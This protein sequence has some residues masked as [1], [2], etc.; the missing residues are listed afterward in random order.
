M[1]FDS[2]SGP[3]EQLD[4][5]A[6]AVAVF[7]DEKPSDGFL[8]KLDDLS[9]G[10]VKSAIDAEEFSGKEGETAFF[11]LVGNNK[12]KARR[13]M[14]VGAGDAAEYKNAQVSHMAGTAFR[15]LKAKNAKSIA[16]IPRAVGNPEELAAAAVEGALMG[17]F[18]PD[19][20][21]TVDKDLKNIDRV[22]IS[23]EGVKEESLKSG[24]ETGRIVGE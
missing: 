20:Y 16:I 14:L 24:V 15:S 19:K 3:Y 10:L 4:V 7:K 17:N 22:V 6:L 9:G 5:H 21:R 8:K 11:H 18:D 2:S 23:I 12:L 1:Q 13:L